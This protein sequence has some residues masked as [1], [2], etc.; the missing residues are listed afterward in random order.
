MT[1]RIDLLVRVNIHYIRAPE[2][3]VGRN[4]IEIG[5]FSQY[6]NIWQPQ[7]LFVVLQAGA[8]YLQARETA[9]KKGVFLYELADK[10]SIS[11]PT[12]TRLLRKELSES[13]KQELLG[14][15]AE[16]ADEKSKAART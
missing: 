2:Q 10:L 12:M 14:S 7:P 16:I 4:I 5:N 11:E 13:K 3:I 6:T 8:A 1:S 15:I 9:K